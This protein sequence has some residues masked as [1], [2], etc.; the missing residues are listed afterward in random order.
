MAVP[1]AAIAAAA[2]VASKYIPALSGGVQH[3]PG[4]AAHA[5]A[6]NQLVRRWR[7]QT[8]EW[9]EE[10]LAAFERNTK[11]CTVT[12]DPIACNEVWQVRQALVDEGRALASAEEPVIAA[13]AAQ[14]SQPFAQAS[15]APGANSQQLLLLLLL[16]VLKARGIL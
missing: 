7:S 4:S 2:S 8:Q 3:G 15:F 9:R 12:R 5:E 11:G 16:L 10:K 14:P 1:I 6:V 13:A